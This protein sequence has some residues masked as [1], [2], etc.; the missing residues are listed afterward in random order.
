M[1][2]QAQHDE[3]RRSRKRWRNVRIGWFM[4]GARETVAH[5]FTLA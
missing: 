5:A 4:S 3:K 2:K 1:L